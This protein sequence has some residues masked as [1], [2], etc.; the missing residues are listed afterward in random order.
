MNAFVLLVWGAFALTIKLSLSQ[1]TR[2]YP[3]DSLPHPM[4]V[5]GSEQVS[6]QLCGV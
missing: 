5:G 2:F 6:E 1:T 3:S 4:V